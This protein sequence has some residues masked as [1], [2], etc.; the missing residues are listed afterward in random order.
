[1][2][3]DGACHEVVPIRVV[4]GNDCARTKLVSEHYLIANRIMAEHGDRVTAL[5]YFPRG[6]P[7]PSLV[8]LD[9]EFISIY[10]EESLVE[11]CSLANDGSQLFWY[12]FQ[13]HCRS[14]AREPGWVPT[15]MG[16]RLRPT[17]WV[18]RIAHEAG[19]R[20][21]TTPTRWPPVGASR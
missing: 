20:S 19:S 11:R 15:K 2:V 17:I 12:H 5:H 18:R 9:I 21:A 7:D 8:F 1:M 16:A 13:P 3:F 4:T 10:P 6:P 14:N